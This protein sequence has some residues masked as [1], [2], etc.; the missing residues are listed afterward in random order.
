MMDALHEDFL[1]RDVFVLSIEAAHAK[2]R[3]QRQKEHVE[4][5]TV[6]GHEERCI[7]LKFG[8]HVVGLFWFGGSIWLIGGSIA[9]AF[10]SKIEARPC[11]CGGGGGCSNGRLQTGS[12]QFLDMIEQLTFQTGAA[13]RIREVG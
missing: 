8:G 11:G 12:V 10:A 7:E 4:H 6:P 13:R 3:E 9:E 5:R 1:D 2:E